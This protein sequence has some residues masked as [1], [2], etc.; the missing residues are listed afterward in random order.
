MSSE[1]VSAWKIGVEDRTKR[2]TKRLEAND[3]VKNK[4]D[5]QVGCS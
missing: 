2:V 4:K 5:G 3:K 1:W